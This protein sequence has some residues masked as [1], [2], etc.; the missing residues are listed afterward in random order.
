M[1]SVQTVL[2]Y[3]DNMIYYTKVVNV[4]IEYYLQ[5]FTFHVHTIQSR[6]TVYSPRHQWLQHLRHAKN[7]KYISNLKAI[8]QF[9]KLCRADD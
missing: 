7:K 9:R 3:F 8:K 2:L 6:P 1:Q 5:C 4:Y